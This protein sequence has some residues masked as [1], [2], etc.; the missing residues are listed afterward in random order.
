[1]ELTSFDARQAEE[2]EQGFVARPDT[3]ERF[4]RQGKAGAWRDVLSSEQVRQI[5]ADHH[6]TMLMCGYEIT[7]TVGAGP[8]PEP[9]GSEVGA[10]V[11]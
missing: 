1:M 7:S 4:F 3:Q 10:T 5:E 11:H 6:D 9:T 8:R 2:A